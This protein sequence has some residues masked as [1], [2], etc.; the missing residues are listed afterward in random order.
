MKRIRVMGLCLLA[1]FAA[2][3]VVASPAWASEL[4]LST[5]SGLLTNGSELKA[6][7]SNTIFVTSAGNVECTSVVLTGSLNNNSA[8]KLTASLTE[9]ALTGEEPGKLC[10]STAPFGPAQ[11]TA[12]D[13]PWSVSFTTKGAVDIKGHVRIDFVYPNA[14]SVACIFE[15]KT[16]KASANVDGAPITITITKQVFKLSKGS[17]PGVPSRV[18]QAARWR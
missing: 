18:K 3:I 11:A 14:G 17:N 5:K 7:S 13:L 12:E 6:T 8:S 2:S 9:A 16:V 1:S 4:V 10:K 15:A